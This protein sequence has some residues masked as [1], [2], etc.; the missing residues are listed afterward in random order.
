MGDAFTCRRRRGL[1]R[2]RSDV[3]ISV[4]GVRRA[5]SASAP[6][7]SPPSSSSSKNDVHDEAGASAL[8]CPWAEGEEGERGG[9]G[10]GRKRVKKNIE[11][12]KCNATCV[13]SWPSSSCRRS[14]AAVGWDGPTGNDEE[15]LQASSPSSFPFWVSLSSAMVGVISVSFRVPNGCVFASP[16]V[17]CRDGL[18]RPS[19]AAGRWRRAVGGALS[20]SLWVNGTAED[21]KRDGEPSRTSLS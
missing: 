13:P 14:S 1:R 18:P 7:S 19:L 16:L 8:F 12:G 10:E 2:Y 5:S 3:V 4:A 20:G 6:S 21:A 9:P 17:G 11:G 15:A